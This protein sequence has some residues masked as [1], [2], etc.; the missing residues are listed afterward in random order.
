MFREGRFWHS[1]R[2]G[3]KR[4][5]K[6]E[7]DYTTAQ[8]PV[9]KAICADALWLPQADLLAPARDVKRIADAVAKVIEG[10]DELRARAR[11]RAGRNR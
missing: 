8:T 7:P 9:A 10:A 1:Q 2:L 3:G 5:R 11:R 4:R 6:G